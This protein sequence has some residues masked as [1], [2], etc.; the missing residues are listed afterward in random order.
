MVLFNGMA[1]TS[2]WAALYFV[3]LM[4]FGN[5]VLFNLLVAILVEGFQESKEEEKRQL[6]DEARKQAEED[7]VDRKR[8]EEM[9]LYKTP[10]QN[11][12][13]GGGSSL[14]E[15]G[16]ELCTCGL[17]QGNNMD[18]SRM[19]SLPTVLQTPSPT[20]DMFN[21]NQTSPPS[22]TIDS[23][24]QL[25]APYI[26]HTL[27]TPQGSPRLA[28]VAELSLLPPPL[29]VHIDHTSVYRRNSSDSSARSSWLSMQG[30]PQHPLPNG[31]GGKSSTLHPQSTQVSRVAFPEQQPSPATSIGSQH[32]AQRRCSSAA[33]SP[34]V[35]LSRTERRRLSA[36]TIRFI[37]RN[38]T[39]LESDSEEDELEADK[40]S[41]AVTDRLAQLRPS[42]RSSSL[43]GSASG[44]AGNRVDHDELSY[45][46]LISL[47]SQQLPQSSPPVGSNSP[48]ANISHSHCNGQPPQDANLR[49]LTPVSSEEISLQMSLPVPS[50][51]SNQYADRL[52]RHSSFGYQDVHQHH[53]TYRSRMNS[54]GGNRRP[55]FNPYCRIHG[56]RALLEAYARDNFIKA[57]QELQAA[58]AEEERKAEAKQNSRWR[59]FLRQTF[60][61]TRTDWSLYLFSPKNR[62][63]LQC[64]Y[65]AQQK[66]FDY[67]VLFF[68]GLNCITLAMERPS[69][70]PQSAERYFLTI[71]G[72]IFTVIFTTEMTIKVIAIGC[73]VGKET[74]FKD[75]WNI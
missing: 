6:E 16:R 9:M 20:A 45:A 11:Y 7:A 21:V 51:Y 61:Y 32:S 74:Y 75:G 52:C 14:L 71:S 57:S 59:L 15:D 30:S 67:G 25:N 60:I 10:S 33:A 68:I 34:G 17:L 42:Q 2:P 31:S 23:I 69:I 37:R 70:P 46:A 53:D 26:T 55:S 22:R 35:H 62:L 4:T 5:Y 72:Y 18:K 28:S 36:R 29:S 43:G 47:T 44:Y 63:R 38:R 39:L 24:A 40:A 56:R 65:L 13:P 50:V 3:A 54:W 19:L 41:S 27:A 1:Q 8:E 48:N 12:I 58:L 66:W 73:C 49:R 64:A